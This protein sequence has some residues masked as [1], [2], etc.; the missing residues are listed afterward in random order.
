MEPFVAATDKKMFYKY[1]DR[2]RVYFE[3]GSGGSTFQASA[4]SNV[5]KVY[6]V[7]SDRKWHD[8]LKEVI[9]RDNVQYILNEMDTLPNNWG[10][11]GPKSTPQQRINYSNQIRMLSKEERDNIDMI[12]IDGRF[13]VACCLKCFDVGSPNCIIAFDDFLDRQHYHV[14]LDYYDLME[15]TSDKRMAILRKKPGVVSVPEELI[16]RYELIA[17]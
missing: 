3:F 4:R 2:A 16:R 8:K 9:K 7:E 1:L 13:R 12:F 14:V 17:D 5:S 11:P 15:A 6:S 10:Q